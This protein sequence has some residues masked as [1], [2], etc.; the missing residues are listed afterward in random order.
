MYDERKNVEILI[1][2]GADLNVQDSSGWTALMGATSDGQVEI[3]K[4][5][6]NAGADLDVKSLS[7]ETAYDYASNSELKKLT[8]SKKIKVKKWF[9][10]IFLIV[11]LGASLSYTLSFFPN[12]YSLT[13]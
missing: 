5:L 13:N 3:A 11:L 2:V 10:N 6:I 12:F 4:L 9:S 8:L 7:G 1:A